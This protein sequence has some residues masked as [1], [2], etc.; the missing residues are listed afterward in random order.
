MHIKNE[1]HKIFINYSSA[2][3]TPVDVRKLYFAH[4]P[5][6]ICSKSLLYRPPR[7]KGKGGG[8]EE[9]EASGELFFKSST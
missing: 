6:I 5:L 8:G 1:K 2:E 7:E 3:G 4:L 9:V